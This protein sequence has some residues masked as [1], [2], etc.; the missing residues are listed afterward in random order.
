[1]QRDTR[2]GAL[3][4]GEAYCPDMPEPQHSVDNRSRL[5][6]CMQTPR[7]GQP[8]HQN[9][10]ELRQMV[11]SRCVVWRIPACAGRLRNSV[12]GMPRDN[13]I[14]NL[15]RDGD[16]SAIRMERDQLI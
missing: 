15:Q 3:V 9:E 10:K 7:R 11:Y 1:M 12:A 14:I 13:A 4:Y 8:P 5:Q 16:H 6:I 2:L